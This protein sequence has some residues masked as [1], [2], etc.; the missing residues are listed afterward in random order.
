MFLITH[1][2]Q[3]PCGSVESERFTVTIMINRY[4]ISVS[5]MITWHVPFV[6]VTIQSSS[7]L[8]WFITGILT[9]VI[10]RVPLVEQE[11]L[12]LLG[13]RVCPFILSGIR[14]AHF[15]RWHVFT[16]LVPCFALRYDFRLKPMSLIILFMPVG[17]LDVK[18]C[19]ILI[20]N[21]CVVNTKCDFYAFIRFIFTPVLLG[22]C[23]ICIIRW[24]LCVV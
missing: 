8:S 15:I 21:K 12:N 23:F 20:L 22:S 7:P 14:V 4:K 1:P 19:Y 10:R 9:R 17:F 18:D 13:T 5:H 2:S 11:L 3:V 6:V 24:C 16:F